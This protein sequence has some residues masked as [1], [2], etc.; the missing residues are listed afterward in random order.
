M[1]NRIEPSSWFSSNT[2]TFYVTCDACNVITLKKNKTQTYEPGLFLGE[3]EKQ[4]S[5][6]LNF[7]FEDTSNF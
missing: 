3:T 4:E 7:S 2:P 5:E 6:S 1:A